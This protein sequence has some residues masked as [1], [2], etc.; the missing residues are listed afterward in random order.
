MKISIF[1]FVDTNMIVSFALMNNQYGNCEMAQT[2][3]DELITSCPRRVDIWSQYVDMLVKSK[4]I[5]SARYARYLYRC[6]DRFL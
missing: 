2:L 1:F 5:D 4:L 6:L 3:M